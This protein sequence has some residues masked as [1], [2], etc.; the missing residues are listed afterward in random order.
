MKRLQY[1]ISSLLNIHYIGGKYEIEEP[2]SDVENIANDW[3]N[4][5]GYIYGAMS[6]YNKTV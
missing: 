4:V 2:P 1:I 3:K 6:N 5:G